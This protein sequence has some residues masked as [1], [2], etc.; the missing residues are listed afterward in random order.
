[1]RK[2]GERFWA[3][4]VIDPIHDE[5][6]RLLGFA[7]VTRDITEKRQAEEELERSREALVQAQKMEAIGR[8]TGGVAHDF[9]NLL[10]VIRASADFLRRPNIPR[11]SAPATSRRSPRP[12]TAPRP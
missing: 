11:K 10:T 4:V 1:M 2:N 3:S 7:K 9:N 12:P 5:T 6:G 8:L